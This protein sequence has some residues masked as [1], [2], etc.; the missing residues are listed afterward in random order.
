MEMS[1]YH[2]LEVLHRSEQTFVFRALRR[3]DGRPVV[4]KRLNPDLAGPGGAGALR[5]E[6]AIARR[7][8]GPGIVEVLGFDSGAD[9]CDLV[10]ADSGG[11]S[12]AHLRR[13]RPPTL[14]EALRLGARTAAA[15]ARVHAGNVVHKDVTPANIV[16]N[17]ASDAVEIIDFGIA[18]ELASENAPADVARLEGTLAYI[19][20]EQTGRMNRSLDWRSDL[21]ALG[22]TLYDLLTGRPPFAGRDR[23]EVIHGH[24]ARPPEPP[25]RIDPA[26]PPVVS[27]LVLKLLAKEPEQRYQSARGVQGDLEACLAALEVGDREGL[28]RL[29]LGRHDRSPRFQVPERLYGRAADV[30]Q[31][32]AS[33]E[34]AAAGPAELLLVAGPAGVGKSALVQ[35]IQKPLT[36]AR[37]WFA[38]GKFD[39]FKRNIPYS[40]LVQ[41]LNG[42]AGLLLAEPEAVLAKRRAALARAV[43]VNGRVVTELVPAFATILGEPPP[44]PA[45]PPAENELRFQLTFQNLFIALATAER[46]LVLFLDDLHWADRSSLTLL[47]KLA[48][49]RDM[50]HLLVIGAS[51]PDGLE[52]GQ[53]LAA[54]TGEIARAGGRVTSLAVGP[55]SPAD[56]A[57]LVADTVHRD[58]PEV[59]ALAALCHR[60]TEGNPFFLSQF[61][62]ALHEDGLI[63]QDEREGRW[64]WED[65]RIAA[66]DSTDNVIDLMIAKLRRL[67]PGT[68]AVLSRAACVG[69]VFD[70]ALLGVATGTPAARVGGALWPALREGLVLPLDGDYRTLGQDGTAAAAPAPRFRFLHDRV[71]QAAYTLVDADERAAIH[72][73]L[74]RR[75]LAKEP[76]G[77]HGDRLFDIVNHLN[78]GRPPVD[79]AGERGTLVALNL[80]AARRAKAQ[81]A[82]APALG[83]AR[84]GIAL[85]QAGGPAAGTGEETLLALYDEAVTAAFMAGDHA[86]MESYAGALLARTR[87]GLRQAHAQAVRMTA[88]LTQG[89]A[90]GALAI[91]LAALQTVG[92]RV[93]RRT[94]R[95]GVTFERLRGARLL[96]G[97]RAPSAAAPD[98]AGP[99]PYAGLCELLVAHI[100]PIHTARPDLL[101]PL[102][103]RLLAW[104]GRTG[105]AG[106]RSIARAFWGMACAASGD[107]AGAVRAFATAGP[108]GDDPALFGNTPQGVYLR[109]Y[110]SEQWSL[111]WM[112]QHARAR[113]LSRQCLDRGDHEFGAY[114]AANS[115]WCAWHAGLDLAALEAEVAESLHLL[116]RIGNRYNELHLRALRQAVSNLHL[117][118]DRPARLDGAHF[119]QGE[120]FAAMR[121]SGLFAPLAL[122]CGA[123]LQLAVFFDRAGEARTA[124]A[125]I[126]AVLDVDSAFKDGLLRPSFVFYRALAE[127]AAPAATRRERLAVRLRLGRAIRRFRAWNALSPSLHGHRFLLLCAEAAGLAGRDLAAAALYEQAVAAA[128]AAGTVHEEGLAAERA[129]L[130]HER[131]GAVAAAG[132]LR[133][134]ARLA[135]RRWG[136]LAKVRDLEERFPELASAATAALAVAA[137]TAP[138]S[139]AAPVTASESTSA[140]GLAG[141][142]DFEAVMTAARAISGEIRRE[143]LLETLLRTVLHLAG[144][145]RGLLLLQTAGGLALVADADAAN[146]RFRLLGEPV[147]VDGE[148][149]P[150]GLPVSIVTYA[151]RTG[152]CVVLADASAD[153]RFADDPDV[154]ARRPRSVLCMPLLR[155]GTLVGV[156]HLENNLATDT[157]V[158]QRL[159]APRLLASQIAISL[160]NARL[161]DE[162][163]DFNRSLEAQVAE[164]TRALQVVLD[165]EREAHDQLRAAQKQL[166]QAEKLVSL[167]QMMAGV[168]HEINTPLGIAI[169]SATHLADET[170]R[171]KELAAGGRVRRTDFDRYMETAEETTGLL[172]SNL[173][174][175][176]DLVH[177]FKLVSADQTSDERRRFD[178]RDYLEDL[179]VSLGPVWKKAGHRV[180]L[181]CPEGLELDG[182]PGVLAQ[183]LTNLVV[184]SVTHGYPPGQAGRLSIAVTASAP[185]TVR[186]VYA[187]DGRGIGEEHRAKIFDPFFTTRRAAGSTGL[188][189]HIVHNLVTATLQ[190]SIA[191]DGAAGAGTRFTIRFPR[192][193]PAPDL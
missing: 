89:D 78:A 123:K 16:W 52:P 26:I 153:S 62:K 193:A 113:Q 94:G 50:R 183:I 34:R 165:S 58:G 91:G 95:L 190:G 41:A 64:V 102:A 36:A 66:R 32:M 37:G 191:L 132:P 76:A 68:S 22:A 59:R 141:G 111:P 57:A 106:V 140:D 42:L 184:N 177:S 175:T 176:A 81:A 23:L 148:A 178:L 130:F 173:G 127:A 6:F 152:E 30:A 170:A 33:F 172:V 25:D 73:R 99:S 101:L 85:A 65:D 44:L 80:E 93:P 164:R 144:A 174:R 31:L 135:Y 38:A 149:P 116:A 114:A 115:P 169:T 118:G 117:G 143:A 168:A 27:A 12:L 71:Q 96:H 13:E 142:L 104:S 14:V 154:R 139:A 188:G 20:P 147:A 48:T 185:D 124:L 137:G 88:R 69:N 156:L 192:V 35:E 103:V 162:L 133:A 129:A 150:P 84:A 29:V 77:R 61:L 159:E 187:D 100:S 186:L 60:K 161:Y 75:L 47:C 39:Q 63:R 87:D 126:D 98:G 70:L 79:D 179:L 74:G 167:G 134:R 82:F 112:V 119:D 110:C 128:A 17:P 171:L 157:F 8:A 43:G 9:G 92:I 151:A 51:R 136:A 180:D 3:T 83:Y 2:L 163:S 145:G 97:R 160:E 120:A 24:I 55:L 182:Y 18:A 67:A 49:D 109:L 108:A 121:R 122:A 107:L 105:D 45:V 138:A 5:R 53:P 131:R 181:A 15:L 40:A 146:D 19:A 125:E 72:R 1:V 21:Y 189:L 90:D 10:M 28:E 4:V 56:V 155:Q 7:L 86:L 11:F 54:V 46:P 158:D 166:V